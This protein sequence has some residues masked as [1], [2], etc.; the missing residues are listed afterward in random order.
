MNWQ[1]IQEYSKVEV[2]IGAELQKFCR[3][4][5]RYS[6]FS[7]SHF[8]CTVDG[9]TDC[10]FW[11]MNISRTKQYIWT[12]RVLMVYNYSN[13]IWLRSEEIK[14]DD[15]SMTVALRICFQ[16]MIIFRYM[17]PISIKTKHVISSS[18][19]FQICFTR[20]NMQFYITTKGGCV[21]S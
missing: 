9:I 11:K 20:Q 21:Y 14:T 2:H 7:K 3:L 6:L 12:E 1:T 8:K 15:F 5:L 4:F 18:E 16:V 13:D 10:M 19:P 17:C